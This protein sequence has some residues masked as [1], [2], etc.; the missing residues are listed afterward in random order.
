M[1]QV[2]QF[3]IVIVIVNVMTTSPIELSWTTKN[4]DD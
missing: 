3:V 1:F 2:S 4:E